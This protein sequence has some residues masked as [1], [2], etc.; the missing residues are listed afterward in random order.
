MKIVFMG[1]PDF[2]VPSLKKLVENKYE[3]EAVF[4]QPD[5]KV[6]RKQVLTPP[7][8]KKTALEYDIPVYQPQTL[9]SGEAEEI[10]KGINPDIIIVI[11]YGK[12]LPKQ[13]LNIP[14]YGCI[15]VHA[16]LLPKHR[17]AAPIQWAVLNGDKKTGVC[18]MQMDE[19]LDTGDVLN[20]VETEIG[21]NETSAELFDRLSEIGASA[22]IDTLKDIES[23]N[24]TPIK[25]M[26]DSCYASMIDKSLSEIDWN[27]DAFEIHNKIRGLQTWPCAQTKING[28]EVKIHKS[29]LTDIVSEL[30]AGS[31]YQADKKLLV[32]C[33]DG[34]C[35]EILEIQP[36]G[37]K[38]MDIKSFLAGNKLEKG[39]L[40]G[41]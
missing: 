31:V 40:V 6:G 21:I 34:K 7:E 16:S 30:K 14:K 15:N 29:V 20:I 32:V 3:I 5:K 17:G 33:G 41:V 11:A 2:A 1:T 23:G 13:I 18:I 24:I 26:G 10:I 25:Q 19:G 38:K 22:L 8:V 28:K 27:K 35:I 39:S 12:I 4:T 37:K 9:K 36:S